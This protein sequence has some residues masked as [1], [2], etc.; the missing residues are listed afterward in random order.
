MSLTDPP[1]VSFDRGLG[2][3][4]RGPL[5]TSTLGTLA[6][7]AWLGGDESVALRS[8]HPHGDPIEEVDVF[9]WT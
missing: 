6:D 7:K 4:D 2:G 5:R 1:N 3:F 9:V 8:N